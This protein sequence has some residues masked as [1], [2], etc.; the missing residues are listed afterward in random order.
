MVSVRH[1]SSSGI[2]RKWT[3]TR[4][5]EVVRTVAVFGI[6]KCGQPEWS[7]L[8]AIGCVSFAIPAI[9]RQH[10]NGPPRCSFSSV[11]CSQ[12]AGQSRIVIGMSRYRFE[13]IPLNLLAAVAGV[14][15]VGCAVRGI[16][17]KAVMPPEPPMEDEP[18]LPPIVRDPIPIRK[19]L[20]ASG[21]VVSII[22]LLSYVI[23][24]DRV[25]AA[26]D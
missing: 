17:Q 24:R 2:W 25:R 18:A 16:R 10:R 15:S 1:P 11:C 9:L 23:Y 8:H 21:I 20:L 5:V 26:A 4:F 7:R 22:G 3:H 6:T 19:V 14:L 13:A 12:R